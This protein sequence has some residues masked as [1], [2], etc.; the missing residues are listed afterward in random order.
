MKLLAALLAAVYV[1]LAAGE[2]GLQPYG[3]HLSFGER[4]DQM[5]VMWHTTLDTPSSTVEYALLH[6][7]EGSQV[8]QPPEGTSVTREHPVAR[9]LLNDPSSPSAF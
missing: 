7:A 6:E 5:V 4:S 2:E 8:L 3:V 9:R 1:K